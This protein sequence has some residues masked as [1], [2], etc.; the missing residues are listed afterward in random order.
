MIGHY[1]SH[2][3]GAAEPS[4]HDAA[5]ALDTGRLW[6]IVASGEMRLWRVVEPHRFAAVKLSLASDGPSRH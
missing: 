3:N 6:L 1:H 2:P 4:R 5:M